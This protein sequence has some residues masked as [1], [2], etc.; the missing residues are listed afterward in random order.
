MAHK[1][2]ATYSGGV[3]NPTRELPL[4]DGQRVRRCPT[5]G[6]DRE[7]AHALLF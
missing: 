6:R 7:H 1:V 2:E 5:E 4:R 3:L